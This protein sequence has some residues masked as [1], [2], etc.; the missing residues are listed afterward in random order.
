MLVARRS[1]IAALSAWALMAG[2]LAIAPTALAAVPINPVAES[3]IAKLNL[4]NIN[5][6]HGRIDENTVK[7]AGTVE[8]LRAAGGADNTLFLSAGD[9][10][11]ASLFASA[12]QNDQPT[13]DVLN[14]LELNASAVGNHEFDKGFDDLVNRIS[15]NKTN[16][17][18]DYLGA[19][20]YHKGTTTPALPE[21]AIFTVS[22]VKVGVIG[23]VTVDTPA[24]VSP[25]GIAQIDVGD[26]VQAVNRVAGQL[27]DGN[28]ANGE[29]DVLVAEYHEGASKGTSDGATLEQ[30]VAAGGRFADIVNTSAKVSVIFTGHT[31]KAYAWD[32]PI[33]GQPGKTRPVL[34]TGSYG[35]NLGEVVLNFDRS[36]KQVTSYTSQNV[37]RGT[38]DDATL[39]STY[40]R[41]ARVKTIVDAAL[42]K[43]TALG[44][45][46]VGKVTADITTAFIGSN[47]DD[48][49]SESTLGNLVANALRDEL[50]SSEHGGAQI[51]VVNP[52]G[53]RADL[54]Y[55]PDGTVT[56]AEA[57]GVLPFV[58]NLW[59]LSLTGAQFKAVL[60]QM[61]QPDSASRPLLNLG[62]SDNV[63]YT[64]DPDAARGSHLTSITVNGQP[65]D[66][67]AS[68]RIGTF[69]FLGTGGDNFTVF[70]QATNVTDTGLIDRDAWIDYLR[71]HNPTSPSFAR[72]GVAAS[73]LPRA[74][75]ADDL[76]KFTV[77]KLDLTSLGSPANTKVTATIGDTTVGTY[78]VTAG[79]STISFTVPAG[80]SGAQTLT[81][82]AAPS[83]TTVTIPLT[84]TPKPTQQGT[85][86]L[87][88]ALVKAGNHVRV[89]L[90]AWAPNTSL[91]I[92]LD[93]TK[94][95]ASVTTNAAGSAKLSVTIPRS[96]S[97][98]KHRM[99]A[100]GP[101]GTNTSAELRVTKRCLWR[102]GT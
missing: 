1:A 11:S 88:R 65:I 24:F 51:G 70:T 15:N 81:L 98:G 17:K 53:L 94:N 90:H 32:A 77:S 80:L 100:R 37:A 47:R 48:R 8:Q 34:Q 20:I 42:A 50:S 54:S 30:E 26:P 69:S 75:K 6:F 2:G 58:N 87:S 9:N 3:N 60:E 4:L 41:V 33:P 46:P 66:P 39:V 82:L 96:T 44:E 84:V 52:G 57:N 72:R 5:D 93:G 31:H 28:A 22:G 95:L 21:Y 13:L 91:T 55:T 49:L 38:A 92:S 25:G 86:K 71:N 59:T 12:S 61:W 18:W 16:A 78:A 40:P 102:H 29:A 23:A 45:Q 62:L 99:V 56:Y 97:L 68:Y 64:L 10:V 74:V 83:N 36:T 76:V 67:A 89:T 63:T 43:A 101:D 7:F 73:G 79:S 19:N 85:I 14:A 35:A 27:T